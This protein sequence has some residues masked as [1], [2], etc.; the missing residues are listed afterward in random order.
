VNERLENVLARP[1]G[2]GELEGYE[3]QPLKSPELP[4]LGDFVISRRRLAASLE[5]VHRYG[6]QLLGVEAA[7][8]DFPFCLEMLGRR[9]QVELIRVVWKSETGTW[10]T[11][12]QPFALGWSGPLRCTFDHRFLPSF[13]QLPPDLF[14]YEAGWQG[15]RLLEVSVIWEDSHGSWRSF[16]DLDSNSW[17]APYHRCLKS[18]QAVEPVPAS[19]PPGVPGTTPE[20]ISDLQNRVLLAGGTTVRGAVQVEPNRHV[21][22]PILCASLV[23]HGALT[24]E[25]LPRCEEIEV[26]LEQLRRL[27]VSTRRCGQT[28]ALEI[29]SELSTAISMEVGDFHAGLY[30]AWGV[31]LGQGRVDFDGRSGGDQIGAI[32]LSRR[33]FD[34]ILELLRRVGYKFS[35]DVHGLAVEAS[36]GV[37]VDIL[38]F[39]T[40]ATRPAGPSVS[41]ATKV[42]LMA[43]MSRSQP[44]T[45]LHPVRWQS[46]EGLLAFAEMSGCLQEAGSN[47]AGEPYWKLK[48]PLHFPS[49]P[50]VV[51]PDTSDFFTFVAL[52]TLCGGAERLELTGVR[53]ADLER[54]AGFE[55]VALQEMGIELIWSGD[56]S[57]CVVGV[58]E[59]ISGVRI[60]AQNEGFSSDAQPVFALMLTQA[61]SPSQIRD[62][63]WGDRFQYVPGLRE[64]GA[65]MVVDAEATLHIA[66]GGF[67]GSGWR[68][69]QAS[70]VRTALVYYV[71]ALA[72]PAGSVTEVTGLEHI[73]RAYGDWFFERMRRLGVQTGR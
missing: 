32:T 69:L 6:C 21:G 58:P 34:H 41:M 5:E 14:R 71:A 66:G 12:S 57:S 26:L 29:P 42:A 18:L 47:P 70:D 43:A 17:G 35:V 23:G 62:E 40:S 15:S 2:W 49:Q 24:I 60:V 55:L 39:S 20:A 9:G 59:V 63:I 7:A 27:G 13:T 4:L 54:F 51:G 64:L 36:G 28:L 19:L 45:I 8:R 56:D 50:V 22:I 53:K 65:E 25:N 61:A 73:R 67:S 52:A 48:G 31:L 16:L 46:T 72:R 10:Q 44:T 38:E 11:S 3:R 30:A 68:R 33:P 37:T 1:E